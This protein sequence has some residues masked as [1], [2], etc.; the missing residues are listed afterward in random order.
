MFRSGGL[1][2]LQL[3]LRLLRSGLLCLGRPPRPGG[4]LGDQ[5]IPGFWIG[6]LELLVAE[7][8][9]GFSSVGGGEDIAVVLLEGF[10]QL[11]RGDGGVPV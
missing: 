4:T 6:A 8:L 5:A 7:E 9:I 1:C 2:G 10:R 3:F 11:D